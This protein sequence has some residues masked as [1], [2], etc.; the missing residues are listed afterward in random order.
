MTD[1]KLTVTSEEI[2]IRMFEL[3]KEREVE[4]AIKR[5][6]KNIG[7]E[8]KNL[9]SEDIEIFEWMLG[10]A[11]IYIERDKWRDV[12]FGELTLSDVNEI[13]NISKK[14]LKKKLEGQKAM[15]HVR[16]ILLSKRIF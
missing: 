5:I 7:D 11:W 8:W 1:Q 4:N 13:I 9:T 10:E 14:L 15:E 3:Q 2:G 12:P 6:R 16:N